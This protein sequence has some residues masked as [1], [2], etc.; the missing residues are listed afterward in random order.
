MM[1]T[2]EIAII[3]S[4]LIQETVFVQVFLVTISS[5]IALGQCMPCDVLFGRLQLSY[6]IEEGD[7]CCDEDLPV[8]TPQSKIW[9]IASFVA[10]VT[11]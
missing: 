2:F 9:L 11:T 6:E 5:G 10:A 3:F 1:G 8:I 7:V 4:D